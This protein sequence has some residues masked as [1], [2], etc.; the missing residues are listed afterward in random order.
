MGCATLRRVLVLRSTYTV[1]VD[2]YSLE[3]EYSST[4]RVPVSTTYMY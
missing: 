1:L 3:R 4:C 2:M